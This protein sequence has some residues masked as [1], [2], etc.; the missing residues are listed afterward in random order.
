MLAA[1]RIQRAMADPKIQ[2]IM[3]EPVVTSILNEMQTNPSAAQPY[4]HDPDV[5]AKIKK[6]IAVEVLQVE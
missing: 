3:R 4:M 6:L 2:G 5:S 1:K